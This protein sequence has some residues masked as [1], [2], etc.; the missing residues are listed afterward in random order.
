M[1]ITAEHMIVPTSA[2]ML[3]PTSNTFCACVHARAHIHTLTLTFAWFRAG[4]RHKSLSEHQMDLKLLLVET[5][6]TTAHGDMLF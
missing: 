4:P 6:Q 3:G 5:G 2:V 1:E